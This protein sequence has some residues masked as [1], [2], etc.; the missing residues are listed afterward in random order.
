[1]KYWV[2]ILG[3][4]LTNSIL[5]QDQTTSQPKEPRYYWGISS[6]VQA[7][8]RLVPAP[9]K[10][11]NRYTFNTAPITELVFGLQLSKSWYLEAGLLHTYDIK[12]PYYGMIVCYE[13]PYYGEQSL[14]TH[15]ISLP[16][17]L[18]YRT[19]GQKFRTTAGLHLVPVKLLAL[20][21]FEEKSYYY[22]QIITDTRTR[23][24]HPTTLAK[25]MR[26]SLGMEYQMS[27]AWAM[28]IEAQT[29]GEYFFKGFR[30]PMLIRPSLSLGIFRSIG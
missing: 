2:L 1:M 7:P 8:V 24:L 12:D 18:R 19:N 22:D 29:I 30:R 25:S 13:Y 21:Q 28:R 16:I 26:I 5:A 3:I 15:T 4:C 27:N 17:G 10:L 23:I 14:S 6:G 20:D 9:H 11:F